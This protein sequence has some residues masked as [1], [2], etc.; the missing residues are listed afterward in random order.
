MC[1]RSVSASGRVVLCDP[2][3]CEVGMLGAFRGVDRWELADLASV[4][5]GKDLA[6]S[7]IPRPPSLLVVEK[8][9]IDKCLSILGQLS[10]KSLSP[11]YPRGALLLSSDWIGLV[12]GDPFESCLTE[13]CEYC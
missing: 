8:K 10:S 3:V 4:G 5:A 13:R 2:C 1:E 9:R 11:I 7:A 6:D 12:C